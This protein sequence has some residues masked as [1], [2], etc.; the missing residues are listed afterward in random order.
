[1]EAGKNGQCFAGNIFTCLFFNEN[2]YISIAILVKWTMSSLIQVTTSCWTSDKQLSVPV[3]TQL[4]MYVCVYIYIYLKWTVFVNI[5]TKSAQH[6]H[7]RMIAIIVE[8]SKQKSFVQP[9]FHGCNT[10]RQAV[11]NWL[12]PQTSDTSLTSWRQ[13]FCNQSSGS[14]KLTLS[15]N[16]WYIPYF[17]E[18][19]IL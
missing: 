9:W 6:A 1:M 11:K 5:T 10:N 17:M 16:K 13:P 19:A 7:A 3:L 8:K 18:A 4:C 15:T 12:Y 2:C 14:Q